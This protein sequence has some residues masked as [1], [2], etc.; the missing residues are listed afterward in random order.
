MKMVITPLHTRNN[1]I[2]T[3]MSDVYKDIGQYIIDHASKLAASTERNTSEVEL[4]IK[5][6]ANE[7]VTLEQKISYFVLKNEGE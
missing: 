6:S 7:F 1:D 3:A 5:I 4:V 2:V